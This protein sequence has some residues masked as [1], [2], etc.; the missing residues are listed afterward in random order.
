MA[1]RGASRA[2]PADRAAISI[3]ASPHVVN[4]MSPTARPNGE[5]FAGRARMH[6]P[7]DHFR[8]RQAQIH[9]EPPDF[10]PFEGV[11][12]TVPPIIGI[13]P[14]MIK[15]QGSSGP[16]RRWAVSESYINAVSAAGGVPIVL[17]PTDGDVTP[18]LDIVDGLL[19]S[20]GA[21]I[22]PAIYGDAEV[23]PATYDINPLRDAF[24]L[25]LA[26]A[27]V[28]R[29]VPTL[30][31]CRGIQVLNVALGGTLF[32]D[33]GDQFS[34]ELHHGQGDLNIPANAPSHTVEATAGSRV[35]SIYGAT[36][37]E[38]N[39][40]HHQTLKDVPESLDIDARSTDGSIEAVSMKDKRYV[41]GLQWHPE[42]MFA[43]HE[44]HLRPFTGLIAAASE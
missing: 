44:E 34:A 7:N 23:H 42:M 6:A 41:I 43:D 17:A 25:N 10:A 19:F 11:S 3:F 9:R 27:A 39:S 22:D 8:R 37:L 21:D 38:T 29:D 35:A 15:D 5:S 20:G 36:A 26:R 28:E 40:F 32:Q 18:L 13:T 31:I 30:C 1:P 24:E 12:A 14:S 4:R 2:F 16:T 33:V